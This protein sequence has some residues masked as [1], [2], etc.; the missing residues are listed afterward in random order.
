[1]DW[2]TWNVLWSLAASLVWFMTIV[3]HPDAE[4]R[5]YQPRHR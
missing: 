2:F 3:S 5:E 4:V 1:M